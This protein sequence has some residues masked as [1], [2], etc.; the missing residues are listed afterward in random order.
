MD[1]N[2]M[3]VAFIS[4]LL[5]ST[6]FLSVT[7]L[8]NRQRD[9]RLATLSDDNWVK[10]EIAESFSGFPSI[11]YLGN[12]T[13]TSIDIGNGVRWTTFQGKIVERTAGQHIEYYRWFTVSQRE[14]DSVQWDPTNHYHLGFITSDLEIYDLGIDILYQ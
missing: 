14:L 13:T 5:A 8:E 1:R 6:F 11:S 7:V 2:T 9:E 3:L 4:L 12:V 10:R